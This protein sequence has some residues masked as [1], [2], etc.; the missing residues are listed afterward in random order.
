[1]ATENDRRDV[2]EALRQSKKYRDLAPEALER[3]AE[4]ALVRHSS[5]K[6]AAKAA[7]RKLHQ[8]HSAYFTSQSLP[9]LQRELDSLRADSNL[10][11]VQNVCRTILGLHASTRERMP[12]LERFY[13]EIFE[14]TGVPESVLDLGCG[15]HPFGLPW[16]RLQKSCRYV[17]IDVDAAI[18]TQVRRFLEHCDQRNDVFPADL[19]SLTRQQHVDLAFMLKIAP[20]MEQQDEGAFIRL[21]AE[22]RANW[23]VLSFPAASLGGA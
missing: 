11:E 23:K 18:C 15:L 1:M 21:F 5:A 6:E 17:A 9:R 22:C 10:L 13:R 12:V 3:V 16:M 19:L 8:V 14:T 2:L 20:C 7:K 4:W